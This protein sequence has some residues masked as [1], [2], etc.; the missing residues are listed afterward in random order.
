MKTNA[1][2][3]RIQV[4]AVRGALIAIVL[5]GWEPAVM[6]DGEVHGRCDEAKVLALVGGG[7]P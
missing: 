5:A 2:S 4:A 3:A 7:R 1:S 6:V